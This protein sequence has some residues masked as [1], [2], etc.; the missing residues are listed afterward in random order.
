MMNSTKPLYF[1]R[2]EQRT[3]TDNNVTCPK[4][5]WVFSI[6]E[7]SVR[8]KTNIQNNSGSSAM[9]VTPLEI[10]NWLVVKAMKPT[11]WKV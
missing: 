8:Q 9:I 6:V 10:N 11:T 1:V 2:T 3:M 4:V 7:C 5:Q